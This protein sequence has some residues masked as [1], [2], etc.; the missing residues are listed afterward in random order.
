MKMRLPALIAITALLAM[1]GA[2][3]AHH[4]TAM[5]DTAKAVTY[6]GVITKMVWA[7]PHCFI[8]FDGNAETDPP[9]AP[10]QH[11]AVEGQS[12]SVMHNHGGWDEET[13]KVGDKIVL[14]GNPRR[15]GQLT[16]LLISA[17]INGK[18][19]QVMARQSVTI[20]TNK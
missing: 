15:D 13:A 16:M 10:L 9:N 2:M 14:T 1:P 20:D 18:T 3:W 6:R 19:F 8:Y 4:S 17:T 5:F 11:W 12:P 7:N